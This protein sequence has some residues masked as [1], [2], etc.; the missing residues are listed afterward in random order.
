MSMN[1]WV[2]ERTRE[3]IGRSHAGRRKATQ[4]GDLLAGLWHQ[5]PLSTLPH[6]RRIFLG[7]K[8]DNVPLAGAMSLDALEDA[9]PT[10]ERQGA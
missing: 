4:T 5:K 8:D 9:L 2:A 3:V 6:P 10:Q 1:T 7:A